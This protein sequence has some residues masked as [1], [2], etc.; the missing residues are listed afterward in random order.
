[1][2]LHDRIRD[3]RRARPW[4]R[5]GAIQ[6]DSVTATHQHPVLIAHGIWDSERRIQTLTHGLRDRG[7]PHVTAFTFKPR[8]GSAPLSLLAEQIADHTERLCAEHHVEQIDLVG[9]SMGALTGRY[10]LQRLGGRR[11]VRR[12]ISISGPHHGTFMAYG[13][14]LPGIRD[15]RPHSALIQD[16]ERDADPWGDVE[17]HVI[18]T[19]FDLT[20]LPATSSEL[21]GAR[22]THRVPVPVHRWMIRDPRVLDLTAKLLT[23]RAVLA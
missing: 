13:M 4:E 7:F 20:I 18:Y 21:R 12:F 2:R 19:P 6:K 8:D 3:D 9:F 22:S 15:M 11:R 5:A 17:T 23:A 1:M 10:Y 16:L 14:S